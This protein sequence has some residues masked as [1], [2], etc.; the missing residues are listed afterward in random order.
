MYLCRPL[1][2][3]LVL[4]VRASRFSVCVSCPNDLRVISI[5]RLDL[6]CRVDVLSLELRVLKPRREGNCRVTCVPTGVQVYSAKRKESFFITAWLNLK[7]T[8]PCVP[9]TELQAK[10]S[11]RDLVR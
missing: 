11:K 7:A 2:G 8:S 10:V 4:L 6:G 5:F 1:Q 3:Y 9:P